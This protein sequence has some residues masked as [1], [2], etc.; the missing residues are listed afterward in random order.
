[1]YCKHCGKQI[2]DDSSFCRYCGRLQSEEKA[3][4]MRPSQSQEVKNEKK[5]KL[6]R[7]SSQVITRPIRKRT[8][9][10]LL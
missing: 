5:L 8:F 2:D 6:H 4:D 10:G 7:K 3:C 1:M 9:C